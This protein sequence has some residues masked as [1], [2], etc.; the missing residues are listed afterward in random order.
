MKNILTTICFFFLFFCCKKKEKA[1]D[2]NLS[3]KYVKT[4]KN[5]ILNYE[6]N[7]DT[8]IV[9]IAPNII[10]FESLKNK[11]CQ[12]VYAVI[13]PGQP[14]K[15]YQRILDSFYIKTLNDHNSQ[16]LLDLKR[17]SDGHSAF[18]LKRNSS[19]KVSYNLIVRKTAIHSKYKQIYY[20]YKKAMQE[21]YLE[22]DYIGDFSKLNFGKAKF[23]LQPI[24]E[25]SL[26][27]SISNKDTDY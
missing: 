20:P 4:N 5:I 15:Q 24:I 26:F 19:L 2:F 7:T 8:N 21:N 13:K 11:D 22:K 17:P 14:D 27:I 18:R 6:N 23:I 25:D 1:N 3:Y 12:D 16:V 10:E 9:F